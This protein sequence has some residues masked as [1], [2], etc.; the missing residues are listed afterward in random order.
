M[1]LQLALSNVTGKHISLLTF[2]FTIRS[3]CEGSNGKRSVEHGWLP[4][5]KQVACCSA[6]RNSEHIRFEGHE[7]TTVF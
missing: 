5:T 7:D 2:I 1:H 4:G 6:G 3:G